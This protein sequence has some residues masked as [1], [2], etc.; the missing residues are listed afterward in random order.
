[1]RCRTPAPL[2]LRCSTA[3]NSEEYEVESSADSEAL[4]PSHPGPTA[5][6]PRPP[7]PLR[8]T[9]FPGRHKG[10]RPR[11]SPH[12]LESSASGRTM[13]R[14]TGAPGCLT[15]PETGGSTRDP[16][17]PWGSCCDRKTLWRLPVLYSNRHRHARRSR[18]FSGAEAPSGRAPRLP[19]PFVPLMSPDYQRAFCRGQQSRRLRPACP[20]RSRAYSRAGVQSTVRFRLHPLSTVNVENLLSV[21]NSLPRAVSAARARSSSA[22]SPRPGSATRPGGVAPAAAAERGGCGRFFSEIA[23]ST[24]IRR[25]RGASRAPRAVGRVLGP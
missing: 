18:E 5:V 1:M 16:Q 10:F 6:V 11:W 21:R 9:C 12:A 25:R 8:S 22:A 24:R 13:T 19:A 3:S 7:S 17:L 4:E 15:D 14:R 2:R 20:T 23:L